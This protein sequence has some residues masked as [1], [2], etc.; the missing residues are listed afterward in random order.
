MK[1]KVKGGKM[2]KQKLARQKSLPGMETN[3]IKEL[4]KWAYDYA[5][6]RDQRIDLNEQEV[7]LKDGLMKAMKKHG[8]KD[9]VCGPVEIHLTHE[10]E[11][12]KVKI[13]KD[14]EKSK[15]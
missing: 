7:K 6:I 9:Y 5:D 15:E 1:V 4:D 2:A 12:V 3:A 8:K 14:K 11:S 10:K 13:H